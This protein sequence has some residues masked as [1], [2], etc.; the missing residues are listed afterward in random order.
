MY[1][2]KV[3]LKISWFEVEVYSLAGPSV[4]TCF[5]LNITPIYLFTQLK[6]TTKLS[7]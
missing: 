1:E 2:M 4:Q 3:I 7:I 5:F 6:P